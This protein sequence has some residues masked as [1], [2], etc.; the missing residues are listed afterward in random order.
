MKKLTIQIGKSLSES[1]AGFEFHATQSH[2]FRRSTVGWQAIAI[3]ALPTATQGVSKLSAHAQIRIDEL[4]DIY[5]PV[6][7]FL[8][9]KSAK[10]HPTITI[11]CD[12]LL[13][14]KTLAHG[15]TVDQSSVL[16]FS[17]AYAKAVQADVLPW[18]DRYSNENAIYKGLIENDPKK[19]ITS[20]RLTRFPVLLAIFV[21]RGDREGFDRISK[22]FQ[23]YCTQRHTLVYKP[24]AD[25]M[26]GLRE[27][28]RGP[29][30]EEENGD[31]VG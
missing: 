28:F 24:L 2:L 13:A 1:L 19:W 6:H 18:L 17:D 9:R 31:K 15:F 3:E 16:R 21:K 14:D 5:T 26:V 30:D 8:N 25:A 11:N 7:P 27:V 10:T 12:L 22:E 20:D 29:N 23:Q 4:E